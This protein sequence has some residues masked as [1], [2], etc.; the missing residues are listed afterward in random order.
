MTPNPLQVRHDISRN[1][2]DQQLPTSSSQLPPQRPPR[3]PAPHPTPSVGQK[4]D[5]GCK[6][7]FCEL[8][9][10]RIDD[11]D[12]NPYFTDQDMQYLYAAVS[13]PVDSGIP[14]EHYSPQQVRKLKQAFAPETAAEVYGGPAAAD[15]DN[16]STV[17][18][19]EYSSKGSDEVPTPP[20]G[21]VGFNMQMLK[22][23]YWPVLTPGE[24]T[25]DTA[26]QIQDHFTVLESHGK[27]SMPPL[28]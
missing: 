11:P 19:D 13:V 18:P 21:D 23:S 22:G 9:M 17:I 5:V 12:A 6:H 1:A 26:E 24:V 3:K 16:C 4:S 7:V 28:A 8:F 14:F 25:D 15:D 20:G 10:H 27:T 2:E